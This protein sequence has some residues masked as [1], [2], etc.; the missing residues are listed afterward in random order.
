MVVA[1]IM[2]AES[3][4]A[5]LLASYAEVQL[6]LCKDTIILWGVVVGAKKKL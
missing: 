4:D 1:K 5:S 3:R 2:Q 6:I